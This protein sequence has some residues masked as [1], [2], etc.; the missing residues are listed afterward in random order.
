MGLCDPLDFDSDAS[1]YQ[2]WSLTQFYSVGSEQSRISVETCFYQ[3]T[4][5]IYVMRQLSLTVS[6]YHRP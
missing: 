1:Y 2:V 3:Q 4:I 6:W 5:K